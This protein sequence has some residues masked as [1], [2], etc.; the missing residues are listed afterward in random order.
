[1]TDSA[2]EQKAR[3]VRGK[4]ESEFEQKVRE[5]Q[6]K[7]G[8]L[9]TREAAL[10]HVSAQ[11][12]AGGGNAGARPHEWPGVAAGSSFEARV[13]RIF[14]PYAFERGN[15]KGKVC[16]VELERIG[17]SLDPRPILVLWDSDADKLQK[18]E[19][20]VGDL[21]S[22][23]NA[24][25]KEGELHIG[26]QGS[27]K[28]MAP[29]SA[30]DAKKAEREARDEKLAII[31]ELKAN[32]EVLEAVVESD[33]SLERLRFSG[34]KA[35]SFLGLKQMHEGISFDTLVELKRSHLV[36]RAVRL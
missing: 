24:Y 26:R 4:R 8:H 7:Y 12:G 33:G 16:R 20:S 23:S 19:I 28:R 3:E 17:V 21:I 2:P 22:V 18:G 31:T 5:V 10:A 27:I 9:L 25:P 30:A 35:L 32:G 11:A 29:A 14:A 13:L 36:G 6:E 34:E 15:R 1:M